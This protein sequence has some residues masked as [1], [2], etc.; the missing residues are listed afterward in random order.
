MMRLVILLAFALVSGVAAAQA[1]PSKPLKVIIPFPPGGSN[2]VIGRAIAT[3][4]GE[5]MGQGVVIDNRGV[6]AGAAYTQGPQLA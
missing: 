3:K 6:A 5:R 4:L 2:D 1:Y